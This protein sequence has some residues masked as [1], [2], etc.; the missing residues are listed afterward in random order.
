[1]AKQVYLEVG[2]GG[3]VAG[4]LVFALDGGAAP[5]TVANFVALCTGERGV[6]PDSRVPLHYRGT[7]FHRIIPGFMAQGGDTTRG[8]GTGGESIYGGRFDDE[9]GGLARG[10]DAAG[11][12]CMANAGRNTNGSQFFITFAP[13]PW[14]NGKHVVFGRLVEGAAVLKEMEGVAT[15][16]G[17]RPRVPV[18]IVDCGVVDGGGSGG[19]SSAAAAAAGASAVALLAEAIAARGGTT[20]GE[21]IGSGGGGGGGSSG[22]GGGGGGGLPAGVATVRELMRGTDPRSMQRAMVAAGVPT[23]FGRAPKRLR[24]DGGGEGD[25]G[26]EA[27][28]PPPPTGADLERA[29]AAHMAQEAAAKRAAAMAADPTLAR[30][31][32]AAAAAGAA[33]AAATAALRTRPAAPPAPAASQRLLPI[34]GLDDDDSD[35]DS[36]RETSDSNS[37]SETSGSGSETSGSEVSDSRRHAAAGAGAEAVVDAA[38]SGAGGSAAAESKTIDDK[39]FALRMRM[40]A[41]RKDNYGAVVNEHQRLHKSDREMD[42]AARRAMFGSIPGVTSKPAGAKAGGGESGK[43]KRYAEDGTEVGEPALPAYMHESAAAAEAGAA[44][45][46]AREERKTGSYGWNAFNEDAQ[47]RAYERRVRDLPT[48]AAAG[49]AGSSTSG[50]GGSSSSSSSALV[51]AGAAAAAPAT[52]AD[53]AYGVSDGTSAVCSQ[54]ILAHGVGSTTTPAQ[55]HTTRTLIVAGGRGAHGGGAEEAG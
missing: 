7:G 40:N 52:A 8:D 3:R 39:L 20:G 54:G 4:R 48:P 11:L 27:A 34:A 29:L 55:T 53:L 6:S 26:D 38:A 47:V 51:L 41:G 9:A 44:A 43:R 49:G 31:A 17:D 10:H 23:T 28:P 16:P 5:R 12:L 32:A 36:D 2:I 18:T 45:S 21:G 42:A 22:G 19:G 33:A 1:M 24:A 14:L 50:G 25:G 46:V 13:A 35:S 15:G 37:D 30:A